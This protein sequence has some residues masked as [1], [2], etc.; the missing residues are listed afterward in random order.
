MVR[1]RPGTMVR[2]GLVRYVEVA[3]RTSRRRLD[4]SLLTLYVRHFPMFPGLRSAY[5]PVAS[6]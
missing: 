1:P 4:A 6:A 5:G 2:G 3:D